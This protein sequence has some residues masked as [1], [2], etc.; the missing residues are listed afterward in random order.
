L[1][2]IKAIYCLHRLQDIE[3]SEIAVTAAAISEM[4]R[5]DFATQWPSQ[6]ASHVYQ[7]HFLF[8]LT[9]QISSAIDITASLPSSAEFELSAQSH[10]QPISSHIAD[11][12]SLQANRYITIH[13]RVIAAAARPAFQPDS[14]LQPRYGNT[15][16]IRLYYQFESEPPPDF[17]RRHAFAAPYFLSL[18]PPRCAPSRRADY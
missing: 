17:R 14:R 12:A 5:N 2:G 10:Y 15:T 16:V 11:A 13:L 7:P 3:I 18:P 9:L 1:H 4:L 6:S 8:S